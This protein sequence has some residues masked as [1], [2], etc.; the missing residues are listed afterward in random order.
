[1]ILR[2]GEVAEF[3][4]HVPHWFTAVGGPAELLSIFGPQGEK[5]HVRAKPA[6][7]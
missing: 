3:D 5:M 1:M 7:R 2:A 4:T 6:N